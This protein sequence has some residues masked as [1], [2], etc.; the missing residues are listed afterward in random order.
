MRELRVQNPK[1]LPRSSE[2]VPVSAQY[3]VTVESSNVKK[4][5]S[6]RETIDCNLGIELII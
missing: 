6:L 4:Q 5:K 3:A 1:G 2:E